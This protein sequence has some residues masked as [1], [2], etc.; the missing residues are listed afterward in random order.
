MSSRREAF[1]DR[2]YV[3]PPSSLYQIWSYWY[4]PWCPA[5]MRRLGWCGLVLDSWMPCPGPTARQKGRAAP[6]VPLGENVGP[7]IDDTSEGSDHVDP[8]S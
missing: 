8:M 7:S 3:L 2:V 5:K 1:L 6:H 4:A